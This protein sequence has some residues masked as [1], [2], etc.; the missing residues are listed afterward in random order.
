MPDGLI[1]PEGKPSVAPELSG[2]VPPEA[3]AADLTGLGSRLSGPIEQRTRVR[4]RVIGVSVAMAFILYLD[5]VCLGEI[6]KLE[7]FLSDFYPSATASVDDTAAVR[8]RLGEVLGAFFFTYAFF[9]IPAGWASDRFGG[10]TMLTIYIVAWS[11]MTALTGLAVSLTGLLF[12]RL[13][14][15]VAQA[16]AYPTSGGVI[17][18]WFR[19]ENRSMASGWVSMGGRIGGAVAPFLTTFLIL[20]VGSWRTVLIVYAIVGFIIAAVYYWVI[21]DRPI[22]H[23]RINAAEAQWIGEPADNHRS[24]VS[25]IL[26]MLWACFKSRTLWLNSI[27]QFATNVGWAFLITW[28]PTYL[29]DR[30]VDDVTGGLMVSFILGVGIPAQLIGGW[31]GDRCVVKLGLRWGRVVPVAVASTIAGSAYLLCIGLG[32]VWAIVACC[33]TVSLMTDISN[34]SF[35]A[36]IT[37]IGGRNTSGIFAWSNMWGN[38]GAALTSTVLPLLATWGLAWGYGDTFMFVFL[39]SAFI[40]SGLAVLGMDATKLVQAPK[41]VA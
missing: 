33:A 41:T 11:A 32:S 10:R 1:Q 13:A 31:I 8:A 18:K 6:V 7:S 21:R 26:P 15:G 24:E 16:G 20:Q 9:Q 12:A 28:L 2:A 40:I 30:G 35:W 25:D 5:R 34:P 17:R 4:Y 22:D 37:D 29:K 23:P 3:R 36:L 19:S 39:G 14:L 27:V 38:F